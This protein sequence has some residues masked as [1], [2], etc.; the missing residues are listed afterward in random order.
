M[1]L[2]ERLFILLIFVCLVSCSRDKELVLDVNPS[3]EDLVFTDLADRWDEAIPLGNGEIGVLVWE[4]EERLRFS[5]DR[6]DLWDLRPSDSLSGSNYSFEWIK[7]HIRNRNYSPV[8]EKFDIPYDNSPAPSKIPGAALEFD[9]RA[10]GIPNEVHLYLDDA[11]CEVKWDSGVEMQTFVHAEKPV[12]WFVFRN[13]ESDITP[14]IVPPCYEETALS[15][16]ADSHADGLSLSRLGY[17]QGQVT[18]EKNTARYHQVGYGGFY[19]DVNV[20]W[21]RV[22]NTLYGVWSISSSFETR[23][24][25][26]EVSDAFDMGIAADY[27]SHS[28]YWKSYWQASCVSV[29]DTVLQRQYKNEMY[30]FGSSS[31]ENS[32]PIS[33]QSVWTADDGKL[34]PWKGDYHHDLNTQLSYWPAFAGNHLKETGGYLNTLW[35]QMDVYRKYTREF[36]HAKGLNVPGV[37][38]LAGEPMGGWAQ[39]AMSQTIG[40][41]LAQYFY[42]YWKYSADMQFLESRAYPFV[43][44]VS[45]FLEDMSFLDKN[46]I[47]RL[48]FSTSPEVFDNTVDAWFTDMTNYD[49]ALMKFSF[50]AASEMASALGLVEES[51]HWLKIISELPEFDLDEDGALTFAK[52]CPYE[53]SHRHFS[54]AMAF[55]P[56][57]LIDCSQGEKS[58]NIIKAT[59]K[60]LE[61]CGPEFWCGYSY[62]WLANMYARMSDGEKAADALR[63]FATCFCSSNTFHLN[64]DQSGTGKSSYTYR[65]FTLEGNF[66]FAS[67]LQ[68]MLIQSHTGVIRVFPAIP[69][70]W[71]NVSFENLRAIGAFLVSSSME[72]GKVVRLSITSEMGGHASVAVPGQ[73]NLIYLNFKP[74]ETLKVI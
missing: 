12:G 65:P 56:L 10:L 71:K 6:T 18:V 25:D 14:V 28:V 63:T 13:L 54:N 8:Q 16:K 45:V 2:M 39:Y 4:K 37:A 5:L 59:V 21:H 15:A 17:V 52:G 60:K 36:F 64:G 47:R 40:A 11:V 34:P 31:R 62:S 44:E 9:I 58:E 30:K 19:Y 20:K 7:E 46:G 41:W 3:V 51:E 74:G 35:N 61:D 67:G 22:R 26:D 69:E 23:T 53:F 42:L 38:T 68:E 50:K 29:P 48:E 43:K 73:Q 27:E 32:Y 57:G 66:A 70:S 33:L 49:L 1:I 55:H 72:N 24:A